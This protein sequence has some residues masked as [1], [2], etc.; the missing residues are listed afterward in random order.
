MKN[1]TRVDEGR[2][3][4]VPLAI[5]MKARAVLEGRGEPGVR[6]T[7]M[8]VV[9]VVQEGRRRIPKITAG[10]SEKHKNKMRIIHPTHFEVSASKQQHESVSDMNTRQQPQPRQQ[11][12]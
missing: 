10:M 1:R 6:I 2:K 3:C 11:K 4:G 5:K 9:T 8:Y 7:R 12:Q